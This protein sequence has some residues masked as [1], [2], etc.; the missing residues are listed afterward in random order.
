MEYIADYLEAEH[1]L[2]RSPEELVETKHLEI[3][4]V[5]LRADD[6]LVD[7]VWDYVDSKE[8]LSSNIINIL[9]DRFRQAEQ[10]FNN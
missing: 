2:W 9:R 1:G 5:L 10:D 7:T 8:C 4:E 3:L 6:A